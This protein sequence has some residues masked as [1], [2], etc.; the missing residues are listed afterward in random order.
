[1]ACGSRPTG[2]Y[3]TKRSCGG[4]TP[5]AG[6]CVPLHGERPRHVALIGRCRFSATGRLTSGVEVSGPAAVRGLGRASSRRCSPGLAKGQATPVRPRPVAGGAPAWAGEL[7]LAS[8]EACAASAE[9]AAAGGAAQEV[10]SRNSARPRRE[11]DSA[12]ADVPGS[13]PRSAPGRG[14]FSSASRW[15]GSK[16]DSN[17]LRRVRIQVRRPHLRSSR[18]PRPDPAPGQPLP[19]PL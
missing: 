14:S 9:P 16:C 4:A 2:R 8:R 15:E 19:T 7:A 10:A 5:S 11:A 12:V 18:P 3:R 6:L 1:M 17:T 13:S